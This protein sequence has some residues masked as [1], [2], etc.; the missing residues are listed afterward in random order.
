MVTLLDYGNEGLELELDGINAT[1]LS[2]Q[3]LKGLADEQKAFEEAVRHPIQSSPLREIIQ[4]G[5][6]VA[7]VI[8]DIT[9]PLP[10]DRLLPWLFHELH[11]IPKENFTIIT[12]TGTHRGHTPEELETMLGK[13]IVENYRV[14]DHKGD[15]PTGLA[16][17][18]ESKFGYAVYFNDH[19]V[20]ADRRIIMGFIEPHF[21]AG[22]SGGYKAVFPGIANKDTIMQYHNAHVI[23]DARSTWGNLDNN[24]T[25]EQIYANGSLLP[26]D[27]CI[28]LAQN[29]NREITKFFCGDTTAAFHEGCAFVKETAM[30]ACPKPFPIV[31]TTNSGYPLDQ[32][33]YQAVK[34]MSAAAQI[35]EDD[36]LIITAA[37]CNDGFPNHGNFKKL[38]FEY[39][40]PSAFLAAIKT[41]GFLLCDQWQVQLLA[42]ILEK[43][44]VALFSELD[45]DEVVRSH[46]IPIPNLAD[47]LNR[48]LNR[49]GRNTPVAILPEGPQT[50]PY[51]QPASSPA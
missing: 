16:Y 12:G 45:P 46:L 51:L 50:I 44:R 8:P 41:P 23:G 21:M 10:N 37:K 38:L 49:I 20:K 33:L 27:F 5:D 22:F 24:P 4:P 25:Q 19:Y 32:N 17:A 48:E 7:V 34:G 47:A 42:I 18:G 31:I 36:G 30:I 2:P 43:A 35:V 1:I 13:E 3:Y 11:Q 26:I 9:R 28:N 14:V 6:R 29:R 40:S 15:E 39:D